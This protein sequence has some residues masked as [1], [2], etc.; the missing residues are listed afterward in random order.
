MLTGAGI[1]QES[2]IPTFRGEGGLWRN[3]RAEDLAT[4]E[5]FQRDPILV[6]EWYEWRKQICAK[7]NPNPAHKLIVSWEKSKEEFHLFTQNVDGLHRRAGSRRITSL[8]GEI[9]AARCTKCS[10]LISES[11]ISWGHLPPNC[12][13]CNSILRPHI[14]WFGETYFAGDL[15][16]AYGFLEDTDLLVIIG[17]SG[18]VGVPV[19]LAKKAKNSG[20]YVVEINPDLTGY[21]DFM[22]LRIPLRARKFAELWESKEK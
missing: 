6:W 21:S 15:E 5:A 22:D 16:H 13:V 8:H 10:N 1:S 7:A 18:A 2:G 9:F 12:S 14:V 4:P 17:T 3:F 20:A 19:Y 11:P